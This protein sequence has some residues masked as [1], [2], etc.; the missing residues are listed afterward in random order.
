MQI[1]LYILVLHNPNQYY[2]I[3]NLKIEISNNKI[4][5]LL[6]LISINW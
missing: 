5:N 4:L 1:Y 2:Y 6:L 3:T